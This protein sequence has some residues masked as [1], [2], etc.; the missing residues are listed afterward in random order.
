MRVEQGGEPAEAPVLSPAEANEL[1]A[2]AQGTSSH[3]VKQTIDSGIV[4]PGFSGQPASTS[5]GSIWYD[6]TS[7]QLMYFDGINNTSK[8]L[9]AGGGGGV[10]S[11][12][13]GDGL[14]GG[15]ITSSGTIALED[16]GTPG[17]YVKVTTDDKG[18]VVSGVSKLDEGD[19]PDV[20][21][22]PGRVSGDA[23]TSGTI[24]GNTAIATSGSVSG[25]SVSTYLLR[26]SPDDGD[27]SKYI[28]I[29]APAHGD[30]G[31]P[32]K[33][34]LPTRQGNAGEILA[35]DGLGNL[36]WKS[37]PS[38]TVTQVTAQAPLVSSGG[39]TPEL[40]I[41]KAS[42]MQDGYLSAADWSTFNSKLSSTLP[43][44]QI[45]VGNNA[46]V[47]TGVIPSGDVSMD[48][49]GAF[50]VQKLR[51]KALSGTPPVDGQVLKYVGNG[52]NEWQPV[53]LT[54][55]DIK[56][57][58]GTSAFNVAGC[59][60]GQTVKWSSLTDTFT[61]EDIS[62]TTAQISDMTTVGREL[63]TAA[64]ANAARLAIHAMEVVAPGASGEVLKSDGSK[65]VSGVLTISEANFANQNANFVLAGPIAGGSSGVPSFRAL[66]AAD[67]PILDASKI[68]SG[69]FDITRIPTGTTSST[70]AV[71]NDPRFPASDCAPG[72]KMRWYDGEWVCEPDNDSGASAT[73]ANTPNTIVKRDASG[74]FAAGTITANLIGQV[75]GST[76][77][78]GTLILEST[79]HPSK[80]AVILQPN[81]GDVGI[82]TANPSAKLDVA[83][84]IKAA[85]DLRVTGAIQTQTIAVANG[86]K[87]G[88]SATACDATTE[89]MIRY[90]PVIR[91][92]L[93]CD[94]EEWR[95][96][97]GKFR[98]PEGY[99]PVPGNAE[100]GTGDFCVAKYEM[101][102]VGGVAKSQACG[103]SVGEYQSKQCTYSV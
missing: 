74:N 9:G 88:T 49:N 36:I 81:G 40:S 96:V 66:V 10:T 47:A 51:G 82:G 33:L 99:I 38:G 68:G 13:A 22:T 3:Y 89:G 30:L 61:C 45:F 35:S 85:G 34:V 6:V 23:I 28:D 63:A 90:S 75:A 17:I 27:Q 26:V 21:A 84:D 65:W 7:G 11:I 86:I 53:N 57:G 100:Y 83:G 76:D 70:V 94:G 24:G 101:K 67:I 2:L 69:T 25:N 97:G 29:E 95:A 92:L 32:Y 15:T 18:R 56:N 52:S 59:T 8:P 39:A 55:A 62:I 14:T 103:N 37:A 46:N 31:S 78:D 43:S 77:A 50:A 12:T 42:G 98:C 41:P 58:M 60:L 87:I 102:N 48:E 4:L 64:D 16:K 1:K 71:G 19:L 91:S 93:Y 80:G 79:A 44:G 73:S 72:N 5:A 54:I 20:I